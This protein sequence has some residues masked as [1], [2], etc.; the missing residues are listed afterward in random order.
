MGDPADLTASDPVARTRR[1]RRRL[2]VLGVVGLLLVWCGLAAVQ[3]VRARSHAEAGMDLLKAA[4][5]DLGPAELIRGKGLD[6]M[7]RARHELDQ[8]KSAADSFLLRPFTVLPVV[9][10]Q[11]RSVEALIGSAAKVVRVGIR[12][13]ELSTARLDR[14]TTPGPDR[15]ALVS[16]LGTIASHASRDLRDVDLGPKQAL[17]QPLADARRKFAGQL[18][19]VRSA[20]VDADVAASGIAQMAEGPTRYLVLAANNAEMRSGSGMLLSAGVLT[21]QDGRFSLGPMTDTTELQVPAGVVPIRGDFAHRWAWLEPNEEWRNLAVSPEFPVTGELAARMWKA[22]TGEAVDGVFAIDAVALEALV[23]VSGPVDVDGKRIDAGNVVKEIL[24]QQYLDSV[25]DPSDPNSGRAPTAARHERTSKIAAAIVDQ[26]DR[27]GWDTAELVDD[28]RGAAQGRHVLAWSS[29]P[30]QQRAWVAAGISGG[31]HRDSLLPAV[32]NRAG[33]KLDQFLP[34]RAV[35][36][37]RPVRGGSEVTVRFTLVN[38]TPAQGMNVFVEGPYPFEDF[39][40]GEYRGILAVNVPGVAHDIRLEGGQKVVVAGRDGPT[41]VVATEVQVFRGETREYV[42]RF[43]VPRG[44][45]VLRIEPSARYPAIAWS[46]GGEHFGD[47]VVRTIR[48]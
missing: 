2:L 39:V 13:M 40:A 23:K 21:M 12:T 29:Q 34:V 20:M 11:V 27:S 18:G 33:N 47:D 8:S 24:L 45:E 19:R 1:T 35:L 38:Q 9:G 14:K 37:H 41:R 42:L 46:A 5:A 3:L 32:L 25:A 16:Q 36:S 7:R 30:D 15:V 22:K 10:R 28:L 26:L 48:W 4:E 31:L 17:V 43:V 6:R 44:Y